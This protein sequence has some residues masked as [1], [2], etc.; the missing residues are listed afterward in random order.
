MKKFVGLS[1]LITGIILTSGEVIGSELGSIILNLMGL[2]IF[3]IGAILSTD[4]Y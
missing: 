4:D 3:A 2:T 1:F